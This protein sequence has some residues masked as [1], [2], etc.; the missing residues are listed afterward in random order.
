MATPRAS[1]S[2]SMTS[3][4][5]FRE[6]MRYGT[7]DRVPYFEEGL[8]D[9][10]IENW[11]K[12][13][14][15]ADADLAAMFHTDRRDRVPLNIELR[16]GLDQW[17]SRRADLGEIRRRLD[18]EDPGRFPDNW[19]ELVKAWRTRDY[20]LELPIHRGFFLTMGV[21]G[22]TRFEQVIEQLADAPDMVHEIMDLHGELSA[23]LAERVLRE[24]EIDFVSFSEPIGGNDRPLLSPQMYREFMLSSYRPV[25]DVLRRHNVETIVLI[26]YA[27]ARVLMP[28]VLEAGFNCLWACEVNVEAMDYRS[29]RRE[30]GRDLRLIGGI[31]LDTLL[32]SQDAIRREMEQNVP[33]LLAEGGYIPLADGRVREN[34][35]FENYAYYRRLLEKLTQRGGKA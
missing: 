25:L 13:G 19:A 1:R 2:V 20:V 12:Q 6:T 5:R 34:V 35:P 18:P 32:D 4:E 10:V 33:P 26:T 29:L 9:G 28:V 17:P 7:P 15:P 16:P 14:L 24:V 27:N 11:R 8:R 22:W 30:F 21:G 3:R 23:R 31:D